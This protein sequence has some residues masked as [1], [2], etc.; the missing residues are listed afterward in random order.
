LIAALPGGNQAAF[1]SASTGCSIG[2]NLNCDVVNELLPGDSVTVSAVITA[3]Q[4]AAL[5]ALAIVVLNELDTGP[6]FNFDTETTL[7][8]NG[9]QTADMRIQIADSPDPVQVGQNVTYTITVT[10]L[11]PNTATNVTLIDN[12]PSGT[13]FQSI[14]SNGSCTTPPVGGTG[15]VSCSFAS[16]ASGVSQTITL[17][18]N[19][20][21]GGNGLTNIV[22]VTSAVPD[23]NGANNTAT[24]VTTTL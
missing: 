9:G 23:P 13:T 6:N 2:G 20:T 3:L 7:V 8:Q 19:V 4:V 16:I 21:Q 14:L 24:A 17:V 18:L 11:G 12:L 10:N 5:Q 22:N 1:V 15:T